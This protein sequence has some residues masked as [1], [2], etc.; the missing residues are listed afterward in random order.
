MMMRPVHVVAA[1]LL[2]FSS[3]HAAP[4]QI[5]ALRQP[6]TR[7]HGGPSRT[8]PQG[9]RAMVEDYNS[10]LIGAKANADDA[11]AAFQ[12]E[13][14]PFTQYENM[15]AI[16][17]PDK[18]QTAAMHQQYLDYNRRGIGYSG[19]AARKLI[20]ALALYRR[21]QAS[22]AL[23]RSYVLGTQAV[24]MKQLPDQALHAGADG[25]R[26]LVPRQS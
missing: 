3:A 16:H 18:A 19:Q 15:K 26:Y 6:H 23:T 24:G 22:P 10:L 7:S 4:P 12:L 2:L 11:A 25:L 17:D 20:H 13:E 1:L 9:L 14:A 8:T 21:L 5:N